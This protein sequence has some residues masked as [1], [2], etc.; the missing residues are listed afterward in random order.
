V[1]E[2][3]E[4][5]LGK[6]RVKYRRPGRARLEQLL[7]GTRLLSR[8]AGAAANPRLPGLR[9]AFGQRD[10]DLGE[11]HRQ[12]IRADF[13]TWYQRPSWYKGNRFSLV[14]HD[15]DVSWPPYSEMRTSSS[16]SLA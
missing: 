5:A 1:I 3:G 6:R 4:A 9:A 15:H 7:Q 14:G 10:E 2:G 8:A 13:P 11:D 12:A 16:N